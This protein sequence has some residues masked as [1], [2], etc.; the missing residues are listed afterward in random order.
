MLPVLEDD[1][2]SEAKV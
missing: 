2:M 1:F